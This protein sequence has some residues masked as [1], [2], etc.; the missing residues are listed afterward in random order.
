MILRN[1][2][3]AFQKNLALQFSTW[4]VLSLCCLLMAGSLLFSSN[5][6][7]ILSLWGNS[8]QVTVYLKD[9]VATE[10]I[11][12]IQN[13]LKTDQRVGLV[14]YKSKQEALREFQSQISDYAPEMTSQADILSIIPASMIVSLSEKALQTNA[15]Q[16]IQKFASEM[17]NNSFVE[18]VSYGQDWVQNYTQ[19]AQGLQSVSWSVLF[20]LTLA[21]LFVMGNV[22]RQSIF[23]RKEEIEVY[24]LLGAQYYK[25]RMPFILEGFVLAGFAAAMGLTLAWIGFTWFSEYIQIHL[26]FLG[27]NQALQ[28]L[29]LQTSLLFVV[30]ISLLGAL[31]AFICVGRIN[32]GWLGRKRLES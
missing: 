24:E 10:Q 18:D 17:K 2:I 16:G 11:E 25:I 31:G 19:F 20:V 29:N 12:A 5:L 21:F 26:G 23:S 27:L 7:N 28:F 30:S 3:R 14:Q 13:Q 1:L 4:L 8:V 6:Q 15:I 22:I 32:S 9:D